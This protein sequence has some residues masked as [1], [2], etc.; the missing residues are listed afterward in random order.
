MDRVFIKIILKI[1]CGGARFLKGH[2]ILMLFILLQNKERS[3]TF[4]HFTK[5]SH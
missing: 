2:V 3:K 4:I 5:T 1:V